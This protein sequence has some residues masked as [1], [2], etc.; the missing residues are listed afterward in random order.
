MDNRTWHDQKPSHK[1]VP[2][3][4]SVAEEHARIAKEQYDEY[5]NYCAHSGDPVNWVEVDRLAKIANDA[6]QVAED[7]RDAAL[8]D[9]L[10]HGP[11]E[12]TTEVVMVED[13]EIPFGYR[14]PKEGE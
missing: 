14:V 3:A 5:W 11:L 10:T 13:T 6:D 7:A 9:S 4:V 8:N 2:H 12:E 1:P